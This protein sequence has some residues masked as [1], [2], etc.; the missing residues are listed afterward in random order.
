MRQAGCCPPKLTIP[1]KNGS[2]LPIAASK[3]S[4]CEFAPAE[5]RGR[6]FSERI[7][8][9]LRTKKPP[10]KLEACSIRSALRQ[11]PCG[12]PHP[13]ECARR[14]PVGQLSCRP[15]T[16]LPS[17]AIFAKGGA[18]CKV[19]MKRLH[20]P[21]PN[22]VVVEALRLI[23]RA[24]EEVCPRRNL[25]ASPTPGVPAAPA[26]LTQTLKCYFIGEIR[27]GRPGKERC[28][29]CTGQSPIPIRHEMPR[30]CG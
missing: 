28:T 11:L 26:P 5:D 30:F 19:G 1:R 23:A 9:E 16:R 14:Q 8:H 3:L 2:P 4:P 21:R 6:W 29:R 10:R 7:P 24:A 22:Q 13:A 17:R 18:L 15:L 25:A 27:S 12:Q 20:P